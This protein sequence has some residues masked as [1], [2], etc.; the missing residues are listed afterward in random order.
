MRTARRS[1][2]MRT[3][4]C[5][6]ISAPYSSALPSFSCGQPSQQR[7]RGR[8]PLPF[9]GALLNLG[10]PPHPLCTIPLGPMYR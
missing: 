4:S 6:E 7:Q 3:A 9:D 1:S 10:G 8:A 5:A 2:L